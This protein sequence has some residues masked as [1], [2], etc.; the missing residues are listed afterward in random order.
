MAKSCCRCTVGRCHSCSCVRDGKTCSGCLPSL[1][2]RCA[3]ATASLPQANCRV[4]D[5]TCRPPSSSCPSTSAPSDLISLDET[6]SWLEMPSFD[7]EIPCVPADVLPQ[8]LELAE[9]SPMAEPTFLWSD[10]DGSSFSTDIKSCY[11]EIVHWR[12]NVFK[13]PHGKVG[14]SFVRELA[15]L[16]QAYADSSA[17]ESVALFAAMSM[18]SLLLQKPSGKMQAKDLSKHL[19]RRLTLWSNG[20]IS[21]LLEEGRV[22]QAHLPTSRRSNNEP[23]KISRQFTNYMLVGNVSAAIRLL[24][25]SECGGT[26]SLDE[27]IDGRSVKDLLLGKHPPAQPLDPSAVALASSPAFHPILFDSISPELIKSLVM[28]TNGSAGPSAMDAAIWKRL[29]SSFQTS[30]SDLCSALSSLARKIGTSYVDPSG[31]YPLLASRLIA[32]NKMPGVRP[33]GVGEV[34]RR[35]IGKAI[36]RVVRQDVLSVVGIDQ[37]C[38]GQPGGCEAAIHAIRHLFGTSDCEAVLLADAQNAF[39]S[40]NRGAALLNVHNLCPSLAR[41]LINCYRLDV[42]LFIDGDNLF[43]AE[44]TTQGDPLAMVFYALA[45][46]PLIA[47]LDPVPVHQA[48]YADDGAAVGKLTDLHS[49]WDGLSSHGPVYG[50]YANPVKSWLIVK[51]EYESSA[52]SLFSDTSINITSEGRCYLGSPIGSEEY[53]IDFVKK[54]VIDWVAQVE[55]LALFA[56]SQPQAAY[57]ALTHGLYGKFVYLFRTTPDTS[58]LVGPLEDC[59]RM[60]LLP[61]LTG[62]NAINDYLRSIFSLPARLGGLGLANPI[63]DSSRQFSDSAYI[64]SP[65]VEAILD[66]N[67]APITVLLE[68]IKSRKNKVKA[69]HKT[70]NSRLYATT[71]DSLPDRP[72]KRCLEVASE[73][74]ASSWLTTIPIDQLRVSAKEFINA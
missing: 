67:D 16:F 61:I 8:S 65:L 72:L 14:I 62:Q 25:D 19:E 21:A 74:G 15:R 29:C 30:S 68:E 40:L 51:P 58:E 11:D 39:N 63:V 1:G 41:I 10:V 28:Q 44:G 23:D 69:N 9:F 66:K 53:I 46:L 48:W 57:S 4:S 34:V 32:V 31:L 27:V 50:Y 37:L 18:P 64:L 38:A 43:S 26:L 7:N 70:Y 45:T 12:R 33:I 24:S 5:S 55:R 60:K 56:Q 13:V 3:N 73:K 35:I 71:Y 22:I 47:K 52:R 42:P 6:P 54:K 20:N 59:L 17:L 49:W 36:L 2:G